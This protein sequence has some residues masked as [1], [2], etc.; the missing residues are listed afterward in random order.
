MR[1][2]LL[3]NSYKEYPIGSMDRIMHPSATAHYQRCFRD[4]VHRNKLYF[5]NVY[6]YGSVDGR[7]SEGMPGNDPRYSAETQFKNDSG[8]FDVHLHNFETIDELN[9]FFAQV[10]ANMGCYPYEN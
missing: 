3:N 7:Q 1:F 8:Y 9:G 2:H 6:E 4:A 10:Y 5:V